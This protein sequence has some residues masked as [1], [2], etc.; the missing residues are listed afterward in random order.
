M[1]RERNTWIVRFVKLLIVI[2]VAFGIIHFVQQAIR[3]LDRHGFSIDQIRPGWILLSGFFYLLGVLPAGLFWHRLLRAVG[4]RPYWLDTLRAYYI[5]HLG[6]YIPGKAMVVV[7]RAGLVS[8]ERVSS[9][10]AGVTVFMETLTQMAVGAALAA[11]I[12]AI[13]YS[14][15]WQ[16]VL[17]ALGLMV[18]AG[19]PTL[20]QV[21]RKLVQWL[22]IARISPEI[23]SQL[24]GIRADVVILGWCGN[25]VGWSVLGLSLWAAIRALPGREASVAFTL[26]NQLLI[27]AAVGLAV[28]SGFLSLIPGGL[29]VRELVLIP[30]LAHELQLGPLVALVAAILVRLAWLLAE[31]VAAGLSLATWREKWRGTRGVGNLRGTNEPGGATNAAEEKTGMK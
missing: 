31:V 16:L 9:A 20:P 30:L 1:N 15:Y 5:G 11:A 23:D 26:E 3:D 25:L 27:T 6:K 22:R 24:Q 14:Q 28:V 17:L 19:L 29:G 7:L 2:A 4:Q 10:T 12:I 8:G 13:R 18:C 21:F